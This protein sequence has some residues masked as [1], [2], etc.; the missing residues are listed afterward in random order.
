MEIALN[1]I[2]KKYNLDGDKKCPIEIPNVGRND[3][4]KLFGELNFKVGAEIGVERGEYAEIICKGS[5]AKL[6]CVDSWQ[7]YGDYRVH[8]SQSKLDNFYGETKKRLKHYNVEIIR[9][10]SMDAVKD[11]ENGSLD[12]VY[13]DGNHEYRYIVDDLVE[14]SKK[15]RSGGIVSGHDYRREKSLR[16]RCH[17]VEA[18]RG[19]VSAYR[20]NPWFLLGRKAKIEGEIRDSARSWF[21][22]KE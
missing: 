19:Y 16:Y 13:I 15:V 7:S 14:W 22:V 18:V 6:Y 8:R 21:W 3:L 5:K 12:F 4:A 17:V 9:K 20:I 2:F 10:F 11:F 1:Y